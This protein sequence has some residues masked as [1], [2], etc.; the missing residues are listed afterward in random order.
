[1]AYIE[2]GK[3]LHQVR[4]ERNISLEKLARGL[5]SKQA[6]S[7]IER[8]NVQADKMMLD[9][10]LQRL[11]KST[12][13]QEVILTWEAYRLEETY[14]ALERSIQ[15]QNYRKAAKYRKE[16]VRL[17]QG[18]GE[19]GGGRESR[20][21][22]PGYAGGE[23]VR[24]MYWH[25]ML[26]EW[27]YWLEQDRE[28]AKRELF[29]AAELSL[30]GCWER[31]LV[32]YAISTVEMEN[33]LAIARLYMEEQ[34]ER[35]RDKTAALRRELWNAA[36]RPGKAAEAFKSRE[37]S[38]EN[39][40]LPDFL[41]EC[42]EYIRRHFT[43]EQEYAKIFAKCVW[44]LSYIRLERGQVPEA[45]EICEEAVEA[46]R[47]CGISAFLVP[48]L[49]RILACCEKA[50]EAQER[51][52]ERGEELSFAWCKDW[53]GQKECYGHY[54]TA[55]RHLYERCGLTWKPPESVFLKCYQKS[56]HLDYE[57]IRSER[58]AQGM[59]REKMIEGIYQN[60]KALWQ[61]EAKRNSPHGKNFRLL[62]EKL[63]CG[64][65]R[66]NSFVAS[67]SF[68]ALELKEEI[69]RCLGRKEYERAK[70]LV[71]RLEKSLDMEEAENQRVLLYIKSIAE[72][73]QGNVPA[74]EMLNMCW[75]LLGQT[76]RIAEKIGADGIPDWTAAENDL[77]YRAPMKAEAEIMNRIA[78][79]LCFLQHRQEAAGLYERMLQSIRNSDVALQYRYKIYAL[80]L[81]N[82][83]KCICSAQLSREGISYELSCG[84][85]NALGY[86]LMIWACAIGNDSSDR[87]EGRE[88]ILDAYYLCE[89]S[90]NYKYR[91]D[92][93][94]YYSDRYGSIEPDEQNA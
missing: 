19:G 80:P 63:S 66:Y 39:E 15:Q 93:R 74:R 52:R 20:K 59:T 58:I 73:R 86:A 44:L 3:L 82:L 1:M 23:R 27:A 2:L 69:D 77:F 32:C 12:D 37:W 33:L 17:L 7:D 8:G 91:E 9:I 41:E 48:L 61:I 25:R 94:K 10:M 42:L 81:A 30:P 68:E 45:Y 67:D 85:L 36:W 31:R 21:R 78:V 70:E 11:G 90:K 76:Y 53:Q 87:A 54:L 50:E 26:A 92:I 22:T 35:T 49:E 43:D 6:L 62:M 16:L 24:K 29:A 38:R 65:G 13:K 89:L 47:D 57:F 60:Q 56:Y 5:C 64:K 75:K 72:F 4:K 40:T 18:G 79:L 46:L 83:A 88:M 28:K 55:F 84:K 34:A 14:D 71:R 51:A